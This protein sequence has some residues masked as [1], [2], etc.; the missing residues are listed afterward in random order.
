MRR[1]FRELGAELGIGGRRGEVLDET[2]GEHAP[3]M[4]SSKSSACSRPSACR[5][6]Q[7]CR[8]QLPRAQGGAVA[9][10]HRLKIGAARG[11]GLTALSELLPTAEAGLVEALGTK[12]T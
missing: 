11:Y 6:G 2:A 3:S 9:A 12:A 10:R 1:R 4:R 7:Q 8:R 5:S